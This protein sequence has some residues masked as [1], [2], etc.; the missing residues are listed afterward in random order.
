MDNKKKFIIHQIK[1]YKSIN[2]KY[3]GGSE[4]PQP[5]N[6]VP[7]GISETENQ[8]LQE[9]KQKSEEKIESLR[10]NTTELETTNKQLQET[11]Q[12]LQETKQQLENEN[13]ELE[14]KKQQ[15]E[16]KNKQLVDDTEEFERKKEDFE[17][18]RKKLEEDKTQLEENNKQ[19]EKDKTQLEENNKQLEKDT[20]QLEENNKQLEK[21]T[22]QLEEESKELEQEKTQLE[23]EKQKLVNE[24]KKLVNENKELEETK[25]K[26]LDGN[27]KLEDQKKKLEDQ[28]KELDKEKQQLVDRRKKITIENDQLE[29][30]IIELGKEKLQLEE[31]KQQLEGKIQQLEEEIE[32]IKKKNQQN[33]GLSKIF[34]WNKIK[35]LVLANLQTLINK[36]STNNYN[37]YFDIVGLLKNIQQTKIN[38]TNG[39]NIEKRE[40]LRKLILKDFE[41]LNNIYKKLKN[42]SSDKKVIDK[43]ES[44]TKQL[45]E[46]IE[47]YFNSIDEKWY[48]ESLNL[49]GKI[50]KKQFENNIVT[51]KKIRKVRDTIFKL[52][53]NKTDEKSLLELQKMIEEFE[54][55]DKTDKKTIIQEITTLN[56]SQNKTDEDLEKLESILKKLNF[57]ENNM[58][59]NKYFFNAYKN[60]SS[61]ALNADYR[62][63]NLEE[64]KTKLKTDMNKLED[65]IK[66]LKAQEEAASDTSNITSLFGI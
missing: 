58:F 25:R 40:E 66:T 49:E 34:N 64:E 24:N 4:N 8:Q 5:D 47:Q 54:F 65:E 14:E 11:I 9:I 22:T 18:G 13:I 33:L 52:F 17:E 46:W 28:N 6:A 35:N 31:H 45:K 2:K 29:N 51:L 20:T 37:I 10:K 63:K 62:I 59:E 1:N 19:L 3:T 21:D 39:L 16:T 27:K 38:I 30:E 7:M 44:L 23:R 43:I 32:N 57:V 48:I 56:D 15:L 53:I 36:E 50:T 61:I 41:T 55:E 60:F 42:E 12:Q 26:I